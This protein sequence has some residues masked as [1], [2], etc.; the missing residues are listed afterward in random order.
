M[1]QKY[2]DRL[3]LKLQTNSEEKENMEILNAMYRAKYDL[4]V[5]YNNFGIAGDKKLQDIFTYN[6]LTAKNTYEYLYTK[7]RE[8]GIC[9]DNVISKGGKAI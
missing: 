7:V 1:L 2:I 9:I 4:E 5:A 3:K 6:I 8:K